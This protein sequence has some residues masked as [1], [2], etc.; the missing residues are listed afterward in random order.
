MGLIH[1][2]SQTHTTPI[3]LLAIRFCRYDF[4]QTS[5]H[6]IMQQH[7][8]PISGAVD[9]L[10]CSLCIEKHPSKIMTLKSNSLCTSASPHKSHTPD[11]DAH[12]MHFQV[13]YNSKITVPHSCSTTDDLPLMDDPRHLLPALHPQFMLQ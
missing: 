1:C 2:S 4:S 12:C 7:A 10:I 3:S 13:R 8:P 6:S 9:R 5:Y 11:V